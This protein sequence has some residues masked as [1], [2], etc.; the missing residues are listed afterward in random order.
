MTN[1]EKMREILAQYKH[2]AGWDWLSESY[3]K[4]IDLALDK[5][6][7]LQRKPHPRWCSKHQRV[8]NVGIKHPSCV[9]PNE[10]CLLSEEEILQVI[11]DYCKVDGDYKLTEFEMGLAKAIFNKMRG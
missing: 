1:R 11:V 2:G 4:D 7:K 9:F 6:E 8:H 5:L 3:R 10:R